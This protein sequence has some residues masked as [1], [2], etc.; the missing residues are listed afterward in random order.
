[1]KQ[2]DCYQLGEV[3][4]T[5]GLTGEVS[6]S[7]EVDYPDEYKNL[8]SVF[9]EQQGKL[10]PFFIDT[11]QIN[12]NKALVKFEDVDSIDNAKSLIKS[13]L[14]LPLNTLPELA[15]G[16]YYFHDLI[17]CEIFEADLKIGEIKEVVD[18]NGN[19][20]LV[21][22]FKSKEILIPFKDEIL[23]DVDT[24]AKKVKVSLPDGLL[25]L[26]ND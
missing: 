26:Y 18:L 23:T 6:I 14:F 17:G 9:L 7:L 19:Q 8:E 12:K 15:P 11:I 22:D 20:L 10:V 13:K 21:V 1:M 4:K 25:D 2:D 5:H 24:K 16:Q 3:I